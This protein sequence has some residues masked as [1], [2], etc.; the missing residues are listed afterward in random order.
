MK[1][2]NYKH[3]Q[4]ILCQLAELKTAAETHEK[5]AILQEQAGNDRLAKDSRNVARARLLAWDYL[6]N[7][8]SHGLAAAMDYADSRLKAGL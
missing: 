8:P 3:S 7:A 2:T 6:N 4:S 1:N 5:M